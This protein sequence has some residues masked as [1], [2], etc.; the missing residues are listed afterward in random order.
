MK[1][2]EGGKNLVFVAL[3]GSCDN[4]AEFPKFICRGRNLGDRMPRNNLRGYWPK[5]VESSIVP[6]TLKG[7]KM[8]SEIQGLQTTLNGMVAGEI[9]D[10]DWKA[11]FPAIMKAWD[12][13]QGSN[14]GGMK[15]WK[16][17]RMEDL[18]WDPPMI[19]FSI[20]RHGA[21]VGGGSTRAELQY[22]KV[23]V[24]EGV[25]WIDSVGRRQLYEMDK[26]LDVRPI[27]KRICKT[28][29]KQKNSKYLKWLD[30]GRNMV[31]VVDVPTLIPA[32]NNQTASA[33]RKRFRKAIAEM[34]EEKGWGH[35]LGK[36]LY[37]YSRLPK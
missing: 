27:A 31:R 26:P 7:P 20:E 6:C 8:S 36:S 19:S 9:S 5:T 22:W 24:D 29:V 37:T 10:E 11:V 1:M 4:I 33:R 28:I 21:I 35:P 32:N 12:S 23:N 14:D 3:T 2:K 16:L 30:A 18:R 15:S 13:L 17:N 34:L 25:A